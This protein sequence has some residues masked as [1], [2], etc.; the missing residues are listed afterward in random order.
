MSGDK[1]IITGGILPV[2]ANCSCCL[3]CVDGKMK[4]DKAKAKKEAPL[5]M[6]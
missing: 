4:C 2:K 1:F 6:S 5:A 3:S